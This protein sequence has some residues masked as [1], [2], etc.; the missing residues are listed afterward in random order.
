MPFSITVDAVAAVV[1]GPVDC[2][3]A[4][5]VVNGDDRGDGCD[6]VDALGRDALR[7][8]SAFS[9]RVAAYWTNPL[10]TALPFSEAVERKAEQGQA[11]CMPMYKNGSCQL[12]CH[13]TS[14]S[15]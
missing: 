15:A 7:S 1:F 2:V 11:S 5:A 3:F 6:D 14:A 9:R 4:A 10:M 13:H 12:H 8:S